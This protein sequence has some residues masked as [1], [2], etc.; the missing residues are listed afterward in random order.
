MRAWFSLWHRSESRSAWNWVSGSGRWGCACLS[1]EQTIKTLTTCLAM[2]VV[3]ARTTG[4][5]SG[6]TMLKQSCIRDVGV[7]W[8]CWTILNRERINHHII[9][10]NSGFQRPVVLSLPKLC[11]SISHAKQSLPCCNCQWELD[12]LK[13]WKENLFHIHVTWAPV[14]VCPIPHILIVQNLN[15]VSVAKSCINTPANKQAR[16]RGRLCHAVALRPV[17]HK[18]TEGVLGTRKLTACCNMPTRLAL[19]ER[20]N[21]GAFLIISNHAW[22][23]KCACLCSKHNGQRPE[24]LVE[25]SLQMGRATQFFYGPYFTLGVGIVW[26]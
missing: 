10:K 19:F 18:G 21:I 20:L 7:P 22:S 12:V 11:V 5:T 13:G 25:T 14:K 24:L 8:R 1:W 26:P 2:A 6:K 15:Y 4:A 17:K 3:S 23:P 16:F 9:W